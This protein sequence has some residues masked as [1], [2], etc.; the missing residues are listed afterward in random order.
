MGVNDTLEFSLCSAFIPNVNGSTPTFA[1]RNFAGTINL[2]TNSN[3]S[4][5]QANGTST[6]VIITRASPFLCRPG[7]YMRFTVEIAA[8]STLIPP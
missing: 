3:Y 8:A 5:Y 1:A 2:L 6:K 4:D 7:V